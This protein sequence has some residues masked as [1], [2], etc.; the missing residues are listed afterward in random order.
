[1]K[2]IL[3]L[4]AIMVPLCAGVQAQNPVSISTDTLPCGVRLPNYYYGHWYDT[5]G[6]YQNPDH[7]FYPAVPSSVHFT[8]ESYLDGHMWSAYE[9]QSRQKQTQLLNIKKISS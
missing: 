2:K 4:I 7:W 9:N 3:M 8:N 1:M 5:S 6:W